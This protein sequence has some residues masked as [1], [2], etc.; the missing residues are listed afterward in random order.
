[1]G[2]FTPIELDWKGSIYT[3]KPHR[4]MGMISVIED[5]I[6]L[7]ELQEFCRRGAPPTAKLCMA[8]GNVLRYAGVAV[9]DDDIYAHAFAGKQEMEAVIETAM[10]LMKMMMPP[11]AR[12][13]MDA[14]LA[15]KGAEA[16]AA[17]EGRDPG[18]PPGPARRSS[19]KPTRRRSSSANG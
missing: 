5:A 3:I 12:A 16:P 19:R 11:A 9:T 18:N 4:I 17:T 8:Y 13:R 6:T 7:A 15:N 10:G 1:M 14:A 2:V